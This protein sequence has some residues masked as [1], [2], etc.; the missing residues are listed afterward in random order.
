MKLLYTLL[1]AFFIS[2]STEPEI[3]DEMKEVLYIINEQDSWDIFSN[4]W[5]YIPIMSLE[6]STTL[7]NG[8]TALGFTNLDSLYLDYEI[9][10]SSLPN[11]HQNLYYIDDYNIFSF[12]Y[13]IWSMNYGFWGGSSWIHKDTLRGY[14]SL[15]NTDTTYFFNVDSVRNIIHYVKPNY[16]EIHSSGMGYTQTLY[17]EGYRIFEYEYK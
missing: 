10:L 15:N 3:Q 4:D 16:F 6:D 2:C 12:E 5:G 13:W 14:Y 17:P 7:Y 9:H 1:F 8:W 11:F